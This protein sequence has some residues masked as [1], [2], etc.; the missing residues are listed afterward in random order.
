M[1]LDPTLRT[2]IEAA[3]QAPSGENAQPWLFE[4][5]RSQPGVLGICIDPVRRASPYSWGDRSSYVAIGAALE[6]IIL[7]ASQLGKRVSATYFPDPA[8]ATRVVRLQ[9][10]DDLNVQ[11]DSL[12]SA[13]AN[14]VTNR[15]KYKSTPLTPVERDALVGSIAGSHYAR[16][17]LTEDKKEIEELTRAATTNEHIML[18]NT[19][20]HSYF[21]GHINW[22]RAED[23]RNKVGFYVKTL[24]LPPPAA[25]GFKLMRVWKRALFLKCRQ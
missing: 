1:N 5:S 24:E 11:P 12:A 3:V 9:I 22:T 18:A 16:L 2:L 13:I 14:R 6:N 8:D 19:A 21:F 4:A 20:L 7:A 17:V 15:K 10:T 25:I 23:E